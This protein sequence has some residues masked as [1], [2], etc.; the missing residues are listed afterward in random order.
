MTDIVVTEALGEWLSPS[1]VNTYMTCPSKWYFGYL[2]ELSGP[3]TEALALGKAFH[4]TLA[5][6]FRQKL[7]TGRDMETQELREGSHSVTMGQCTQQG[8]PICARPAE[9]TSIH[10]CL[11]TTRPDFVNVM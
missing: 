9:R 4:G 7:S 3:T 8:L 2:I 1:Q 10:F 11:G 6:N 5:R